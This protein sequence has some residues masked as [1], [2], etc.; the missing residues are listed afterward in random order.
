[1]KDDATKESIF[2]LDPPRTI[3]PDQAQLYRRQGFIIV[4]NLYTPDEIERMH[5]LRLRVEKEAEGRTEGFTR[6]GAEYNIEPLATDPTRVALRKIQEV[7]KTE[8]AFRQV[9]A[10]DKVLDIVED[11]I[12]SSV[13]YHSS[14]LMCKPAKGGRRKPWHQDFAYWDDMQPRQVTVWGAIDPATRENGCIQVIPGSHLEGLVPHHQAE[15]FMIDEGRIDERRVVFAEM[16]PGDVLFFNVLMLH[17][18]APNISD[19]PR[20]ATIIDFDS[21]PRCKDN[22]FGSDAPLRGG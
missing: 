11:L 22:A 19:K 21:R 14:K 17:A 8:D 12:G 7:F 20:L 1:M 16:N 9:A 4:E 2:N 5:R 3:T 13:Y 10:S 18:S 6:D 15:D